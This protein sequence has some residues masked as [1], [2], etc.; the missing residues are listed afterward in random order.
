VR[1]NSLT[2]IG[3]QGLILAVP[4]ILC[5]L[6]KPAYCGTDDAMLLLQQ[7]PPQ[8]GIINPEVGVHQFNQYTDVTL[9]A[10]PKPG[11]HFVY[12]LGDVSNP[13][14]S[15]TIVYLDVPKIVIAVFEQAEYEFSAMEVAAQSAPVG[16]AFTSDPEH[17]RKGSA[18]GG[19]K[20]PP[21]PSPPSPIPEPAVVW[22]LSVGGLTLFRRKRTRQH[23]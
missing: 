7:T 21:G 5:G 12:W 17:S 22:L 20:S 16:G 15:R 14:V 18:D 8:A 4:L 11:Y 23:L 10:T 9:T 13:T 3:W 2:S 6:L 1:S 19:H